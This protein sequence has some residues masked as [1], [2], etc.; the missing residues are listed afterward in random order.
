MYTARLATFAVALALS[1][2][3]VQAMPA[4][5]GTW[6]EVEP[7]DKPGPVTVRACWPSYDGFQIERD[8]GHNLT[9]SPFA[10]HWGAV[11]PRYELWLGGSWQGETLVLDGQE[12]RDRETA[13]HW[14]LRFVRRSGHLVGTRNGEPFQL[15]RL[16]V[17]QLRG[18]KRCGGGPPP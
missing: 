16:I 7:G 5:A 14:R 8:K 4:L 15:A 10:Q 9:V 12:S 3:P 1:A 13:Q 18:R 2:N 17:V 11:P 6:I